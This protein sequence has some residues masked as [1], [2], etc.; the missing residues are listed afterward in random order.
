MAEGLSRRRRGPMAS[1]SPL[2]GVPDA[3][4]VQGQ[5]A[6]TQPVT[7]E[8]ETVIAAQPVTAEAETVIAAQPVSA[9]AEPVIAAQ[10]V[11]AENGD[12]TF[13]VAAPAGPLGLTFDKVKVVLVDAASPLV[14]RVGPGDVL[15][16]VDGE[17]ATRTA[18]RRLGDAAKT[19]V[20]RAP[21]WRDA[22]G[23]RVV[24]TG[25][26]KPA[27]CVGVAGG[28]SDN[29]AGEPWY[30]APPPV[31]EVPPETWRRLMA[32]LVEV[33]AKSGAFDLWREAEKVFRV[34][35]VVGG[36]TGNVGPPCGTDAGRSRRTVA[37]RSRRRSRRGR[38]DGR[39][40]RSRQGLYR[41]SPP[42]ASWPYLCA[43]SVA[44]PGAGGT[45]SKRRSPRGWRTRIA[46]CGRTAS[47]SRA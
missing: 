18:V 32:K 46:S 35:F 5:V 30:A 27:S 10:P 11:S 28:L 1:V 36:V 22:P 31:V 29:L 9:E 3:V 25:D 42:P 8:A 40:A 37:E 26:A 17:N 12:G 2:L 6:A 43:P 16:S 45:R 15:V 33:Q 19:L 39:G 38:A 21:L 13:S 14:G 41:S 24:L 20:F 4:P 23:Q 7:A 44:A 47:S 34:C